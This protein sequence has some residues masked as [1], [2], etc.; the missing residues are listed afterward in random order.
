[1]LLARARLLLVTLWVGSLWTIGYIVAPALLM[2]L[3]DKT[4][5]GTIA[6]RMFQIGASLSM[7]CGLLLL[8]LVKQSTDAFDTGVRKQLFILIAGM[9]ACTLIIHFGLQPHMAPM[10]GATDANGVVTADLAVR[11]G[12]L[13][14]MSEAIYMLQ[15]VLG[16]GLLFKISQ[17][18]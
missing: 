5:A 15:S 13:H 7:I 4:L 17:A 16:L 6:D 2:T 9:L 1:M 11:S 14:G 18:K 3:D 8:L 10:P 12:Q